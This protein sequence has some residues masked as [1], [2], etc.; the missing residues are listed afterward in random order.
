[1]TLPINNLN[2]LLRTMTPYLNEGIY[3]FATVEPD[4]AI[5]LLEIISSIQEQE[6]LSIVVSEQTAQKYQLNAQFRAAWITLT[7]HSDL[8]AVGLTA[9]FAAALGQAQISC[10][11]VAGNYHDHIF[12]PYEQADLA[13]SV[14]KKLQQDA[15]I[16]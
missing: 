3:L 16:K 15:A 1:M 9:A 2:E 5:P 14:L 13:M 11:V 6:G 8:A 7:V 4:T 10:N 12:V